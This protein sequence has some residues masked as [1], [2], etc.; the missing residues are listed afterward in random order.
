MRGESEVGV[1]DVNPATIFLRSIH[2]GLLY[3][4]GEFSALE[5]LIF[6]DIKMITFSMKS[7]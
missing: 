7:V 5:Y 1:K 6:P 3:T 2:P 4:T